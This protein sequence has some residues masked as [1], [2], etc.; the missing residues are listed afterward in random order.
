MHLIVIVTAT[1]V[2]TLIGSAALFV[3]PSSWL[4]EDLAYPGVLSVSLSCLQM[5]LMRDVANLPYDLA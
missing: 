5:S 1:A 4:D 2:L 3:L